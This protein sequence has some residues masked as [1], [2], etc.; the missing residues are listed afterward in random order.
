MRLPAAILSMGL[1]VWMAS[2]LNADTL[3]RLNGNTIDGTFLGG[4]TCQ[5]RFLRSDGN[6]KMYPVSDIDSPSFAVGW[7]TPLPGVAISAARGKKIRIPP[8]S[9]PAFVLRS[10]LPLN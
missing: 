3:R 4:D 8:E 6:M 2:V 7:Q 9:R 5:V 10:A 1:L